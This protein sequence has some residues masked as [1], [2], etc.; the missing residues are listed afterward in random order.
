VRFGLNAPAYVNL[1]TA[2][3]GPVRRGIAEPQ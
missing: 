3:G 2:S 1:T